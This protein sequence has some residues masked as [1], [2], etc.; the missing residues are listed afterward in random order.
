VTSREPRAELHPGFS[1]PGVSAP[2]WSEGRELDIV[3]EG[4]VIRL[5]SDDM[6]RRVA[7]AFASTYDWHYEVRDGAFHETR[8]PDP[9]EM[10]VGKEPVFEVAPTTVFGYGRGE[11]F[12]A[13]RWPF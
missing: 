8:G 5:T 9:G 10:S 13:T 4:D 2:S 1:S 7:V 11:T 6:L 3:V 12:S